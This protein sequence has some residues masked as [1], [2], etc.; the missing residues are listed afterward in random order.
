MY[1]AATA[2]L[3]KIGISTTRHKGTMNEIFKNYV[4]TNKLDHKIY[5][6]FA[7]TQS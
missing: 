2:M 5:A 6:N 1:S 7:G 3:T 4:K